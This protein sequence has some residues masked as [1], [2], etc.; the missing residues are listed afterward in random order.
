[1]FTVGEEIVIGLSAFPIFIPTCLI[2]KSYRLWWL[3][4]F[5]AGPEVSITGPGKDSSQTSFPQ[6]ANESLG[7]SLDPDKT[8][9]MGISMG[10]YGTLKIGFKYPNR[11][12]AI[13][14]ME[15]AI[16]PVL[17]WPEQHKRASWW[18]PGASVETLRKGLRCTRN[19]R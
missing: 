14:P 3:S 19:E 11:F 16:M 8:L 5:R 17:T 15:P 18:L 6:W 13:A 2:P 4:R 10:G 9:M 12:K 7:T 1:M